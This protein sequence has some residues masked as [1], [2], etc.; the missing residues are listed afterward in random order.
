MGTHG[1]QRFFL[2]ILSLP[3]VS[4]EGGEAEAHCSVGAYFP[5]AAPFYQ[6]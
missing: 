4:P 6:R 5:C 1:D 3:S 2:R